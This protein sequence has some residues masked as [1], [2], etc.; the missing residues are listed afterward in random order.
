MRQRT[1]RL[2]V[3]GCSLG[4]E[5]IYVERTGISYSDKLALPSFAS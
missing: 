1:V 3:S 2:N 5:V 4:L